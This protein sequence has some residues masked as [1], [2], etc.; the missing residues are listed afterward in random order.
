MPMRIFLCTVLC[1]FLPA[2]AQAAE[3]QVDFISD[4]PGAE[5]YLLLGTKQESLGTTPLKYQADFHS[6]MSIL[7]FAIKK[8]GYKAETIEVNAQQDKVTVSLTPQGFAAAPGIISDPV[9]SSLQARVSPSIDRTLRERL[10]GKGPYECDVAG[11]V[12]VARLDDNVFLVLP[13]TM[14]KGNKPPTGHEEEFL[15]LVWDQL[16]QKV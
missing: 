1:G 10:P 15:K 13:M 5:V 8:P 2:T 16:G 11:P 14:T 7:R 6:D 12:R 4:P 9:L 3:K